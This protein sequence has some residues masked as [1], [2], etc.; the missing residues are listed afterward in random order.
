MKEI[1]EKNK[2]NVDNDEFLERL[3]QM[4]INSLAVPKELLLGGSGK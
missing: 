3:Q 1:E 4:V 2:E